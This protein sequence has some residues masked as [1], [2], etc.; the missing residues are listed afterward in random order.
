[1]FPLEILTERI[2]GGRF[3]RTPVQRAQQ[4]SNEII[5]GMM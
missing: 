4:P 5:T 2:F 3:M 1:M